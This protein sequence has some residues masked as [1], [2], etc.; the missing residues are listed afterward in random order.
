GGGAPAP[1]GGGGRGR[2][3]PCWAAGGHMLRGR[4][5]AGVRGRRGG[6]PIP[7][8]QPRPDLTA[9]LRQLGSSDPAD[10]VAAATELE[11]LRSRDDDALS[12]LARALDDTD[13]RVVVAA[14]RALRRSVGAWRTDQI[15]HTRRRPVIV[16]AP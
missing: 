16:T 10:R 9:I 12:A 4:S 7:P 2:F 3:C 15:I 14:T 5:G 1:R 13:P 6:V 11:R 8:A